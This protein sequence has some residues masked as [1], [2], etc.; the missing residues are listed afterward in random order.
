LEEFEESQHFWRNSNLNKRKPS[1]KRKKP[2][3]I[4]RFCRKEG[5]KIATCRYK[6]RKEK[7]QK[8]NQA[9]QKEKSEANFKDFIKD[10][11]NYLIKHVKE[12]IM[13]TFKLHEMM[14][15]LNQ[16]EEKIK[17]HFENK[18]QS[19]QNFVVPQ[20]CHEKSQT[21]DETQWPDQYEDE[22]NWERDAHVTQTNE[23][24]E[25]NAWKE[26]AYPTGF[27]EVAN[28]QSRPQKD[29]SKE[30][31]QKETLRST[32][33]EEEYSWEQDAQTAQ[34]NEHYEENAWEEDAYPT[35][36]GEV[37][38]QRSRSQGESQLKKHSEE[39]PILTQHLRSKRRKKQKRKAPK[40]RKADIDTKYWYI[41]EKEELE[42]DAL[43]LQK[44]W[45]ITGKEKGYFYARKL[46]LNKNLEEPNHIEFTESH[47]E[48]FR[49]LNEAEHRQANIEL[50]ILNKK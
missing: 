6:E 21:Q 50:E 10:Q 20:E 9:K 32:Q 5:H 36:F 31:N 45:I 8:E 44:A 27:G 29:Q 2:T 12:A 49:R 28:Q 34:N 46:W 15:K 24:Y 18:M 47:V 16:F 26:D 19:S 39:E 48:F 33:Y 13:P 4:C 22:Y 42:K 7:L 11:I 3:Y 35:G 1:K 25:E 41:Y 43:M 17:E 37:A 38:A 30:E 23:H 14:K 40:Q